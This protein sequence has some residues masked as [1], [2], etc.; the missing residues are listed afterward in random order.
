MS[1]TKQER[2][3]LD[4]YVYEAT[5][6][7]FGGP[8]TD[9]LRRREVYYSDLHEVLTA[10]HKELTRNHIL[11][12]GK[13]SP[14]PPPCPWANREQAELRGRALMAEWPGV[15]DKKAIAP[16]PPVNA[17]SAHHPTV[18]APSRDKS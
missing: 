16:G 1:L 5:H 9:E 18:D 4:A 14:S 13:H 8:A 12:F 6:E 15:G 11:P 10:Y 2:E 17:A 3:F 7:P